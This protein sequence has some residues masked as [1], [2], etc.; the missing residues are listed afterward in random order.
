MPFGFGLAL[1]L[2]ARSETDFHSRLVVVWGRDDSAPSRI[3]LLVML[4]EQFRTLITSVFVV[5]S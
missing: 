2:G 3:T 5:P 1:P 4:N